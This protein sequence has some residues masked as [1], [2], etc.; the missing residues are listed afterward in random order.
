MIF[1]AV[2]ARSNMLWHRNETF[3]IITALIVAVGLLCAAGYAPLKTTHAQTFSATT[4]VSTT[5]CGDAIVSGSEFCDLGFAKNNGLYATSTA[6]RNCNANCTAYGPY[7]GDYLV[8]PLYGEECDDGA[9]VAGDLCDPVCQN[10]SPPV[11]TG[12]GGG[13][14]SSGGG[15]GGGGKSSG[16]SQ[17]GVPGAATTGTIP[18]EG[19]TDVTVNGKASPGATVSILKDGE[20]EKVVEA[21][22]SAEFSH[23]LSDLTPGIT[24]LSFRA[25]DRTGLESLAFS[26]TF[27]VIEN[28]VTTLSGI[29]IPPTILLNPTKVAP[30]ATLTISGAAV[31]NAKVFAVINSEEGKEETLATAQGVYQLV[32]TPEGLATEQYH[33]V[34]TN[35][36]DPGDPDLKSGYSQIA[37]FYLGVQDAGAPAGA[38]LNGDSKVNLTDFSILLF[39][40]NTTNVVADINKDGTV[41][42]TDFSI[43]LFNWTG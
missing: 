5:V 6:D 41:S 43:M 34:K 4:S 2:G 37:S 35:Y 12:G 19:V 38:D 11:T 14:G 13:G 42:L 3:L 9:N 26:T 1:R 39:H 21:D 29:L 10:E 18:F 16:A 17:R 31:P 28:A 25:T 8:Q 23:T 40:W 36:T 7:C 24:T 15:G 33:T 30:G 27:Q 22:S 20:I 32:Y